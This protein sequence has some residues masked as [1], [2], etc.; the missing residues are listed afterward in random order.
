MQG[1]ETPAACHDFAARVP[2]ARA[3]VIPDASH[4]AFIEQPEA[5]MATVRAFFDTLT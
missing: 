4:R 1:R 2:N 5:Y 3:E